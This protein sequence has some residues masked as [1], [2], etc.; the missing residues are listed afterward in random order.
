MDLLS[1]FTITM[2]ILF[3][4]LSNE[5]VDWDKTL[6]GDAHVKWLSFLKQLECLSQIQVPRCYFSVNKQPIKIQLHGLSDASKRAYSAVVYMRSIYENGSIDVRLISSKTKPR[7]P[8]NKAFQDW[9][10]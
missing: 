8:N 10:F 1:P 2:K 7:Q 5:K 4:D 6:S 3:Q 9:N